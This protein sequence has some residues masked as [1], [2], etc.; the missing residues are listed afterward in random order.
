VRLR[1]VAVD[2]S[3]GP[4]S[5]WIVIAAR[6]THDEIVRV[7]GLCGGDDSI[8]ICA[9]LPD[10]DVLANRAVKQKRV[11]PEIGDIAELRETSAMFWPSIMIAPS[12]YS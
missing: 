12:P 11:L 7:G 6:K 5:D 9:Q 3:T 10:R 1:S 4:T 8:A 2:R